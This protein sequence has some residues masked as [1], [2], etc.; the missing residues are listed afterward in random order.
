[1]IVRTLFL[2]GLLSLFRPLGRVCL[3]LHQ[4]QRGTISIASVFALILLSMLLGLIMNSVRQVNEKVQM[5]NA[6]D[7]ATYAGGVV[8]TRHM[9]TIVFTNHLLSDVFAVTAFLRESYHRNAE[10]FTPETIDHWDRIAPHLAK[11]P[12]ASF[13]ALG[14]A[15]PGKTPLDADK[16]VEM[17]SGEMVS[18]WSDW[19]YA[20]AE[21]VLPT[22]D[23]EIL[24]NQLI[25]TFQE[26]L[27][28]STGAL[29]QAAADEVARRH[30]EAWPQE[31][32]LRG[33]LWM[34]TGEPADSVDQVLPIEQPQGLDDVR[35]AQNWRRSLAEHYLSRWNDDGVV[36]RGL[37]YGGYSNDYRRKLMRFDQYACMS[38]FANLWRIFTRGALENLLEEEY[39]DTNLPT[40][41]PETGA[42]NGWLPLPSNEE[43]EAEYMFVGVVYQDGMDEAMTSVFKNPIET[44][45]QAY[46]Q[47]HMFVPRRRIIVHENSGVT[48]N[49]GGLTRQD[50]REGLILDQEGNRIPD[51][52]GDWRRGWGEV[53]TTSEWYPE[54]WH[55]WNQNWTMQLTPATTAALPAILSSPPDIE[56]FDAETADYSG[57]STEDVYWLSNH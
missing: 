37:V 55:V 48:V 45:R 13:A 4:D 38:Q 32:E 43:I 44:S 39:P 51:G 49:R 54:D 19:H 7:A 34:A 57:L 5:Q 23:E 10:G 33:K 8:I 36:H 15:I 35:M 20:L 6:A 16:D 17:N 11:S 42:T 56:D 2:R 52:Y 47:V 30:G 28:A 24:G 14:A 9:N 41:F 25:P 46:A 29:A 26:T 1:M 3:S 50:W 18:T 40:I 53:G 21:A 12:Y 27:L 31:A 22:M